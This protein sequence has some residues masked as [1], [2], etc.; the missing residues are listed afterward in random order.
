[1]VRGGGVKSLIIIIFLLIISSI[2]VF[3]QNDTAAVTSS[4][5]TS[6]VINPV[7]YDQSASYNWLYTKVKNTTVG[8]DQRA[9]STIALLQSPPGN[10][11]GLIEALRDSEDRVNSCWPNGGCKVRDTA[12]ATLALTLA[13]Q[14]T[15]KEITW[16]KSAKIPGLGSGDWWIVIKSSTNFNCSF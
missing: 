7:V 5:S 15:A 4:T 9:L 8:V 13:G 10:V 1:M 2:S 11:Q 3:A 14:N 12:L 6:T 16:L